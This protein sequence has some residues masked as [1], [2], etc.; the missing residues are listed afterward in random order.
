MSKYLVAGAIKP[1]IIADAIKE[2]NNPKSKGGHSIFLG[3]VRN[4]IIDK[5]EVELITYTAYDEMV[6]TEMQKIETFIKEKYSDV[7][8]LYIKHSKGAVRAGEISL[9]VMTSGGHRIQAREANA[10]TVD[11][12]KKN[13]PI[14]KKET[15]KDGTYEWREN[16]H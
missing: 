4:D 10:E 2:Q 16:K 1:E 6:A 13:V 3:Q 8:E 9:L 11:L 15:F 12:I 14:W 7:Q 5:N